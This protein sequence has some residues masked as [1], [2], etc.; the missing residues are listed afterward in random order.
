MNYYQ[1]CLVK[2]SN[3]NLIVKKKSNI[4]RLDVVISAD[5]DLFFYVDYSKNILSRLDVICLFPNPNSYI[6]LFLQSGD[7]LTIPRNGES[8]VINLSPFSLS[9]V[10]AFIF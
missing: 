2:K 3:I 4:V 8:L 6:Y 5:Y 7:W 9:P 10:H 1:N